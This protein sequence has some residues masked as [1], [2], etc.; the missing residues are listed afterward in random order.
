MIGS[1][2]RYLGAEPYREREGLVENPRGEVHLGLLKDEKE[3]KSIKCGESGERQDHQAR[4][5]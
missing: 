1:Q 2:A 5:P 3:D 4:A